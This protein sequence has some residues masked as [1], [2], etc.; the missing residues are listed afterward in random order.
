M[1][2]LD[3][4][5]LVEFLV[6][7]DA[8]A[9][10]VRVAVTGEYVAAPHAVDLECASTLRGLVR[11]G[12]L[13]ADEARRALDLLGAMNLRRY[14]HVAL[15]PRIWELRENL[16]PYDAAYVALAETLDAELLTTDSKLAGAPGVRCRI[17]DLRS[18]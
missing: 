5:A 10:R 2:V 7:T 15:L 1:I 14:D 12:K 9:E 4:S 13:P 16:W 6:G 8:T 11:G 17:R 3:T 18:A